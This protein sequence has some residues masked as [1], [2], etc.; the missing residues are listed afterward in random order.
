MKKRVDNG[1]RSANQKTGAMKLVAWFSSAPKLIND[2]P[3]IRKDDADQ[4]TWVL[5][6]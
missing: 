6:L 4:S 3:E 2:K 1:I 5:I